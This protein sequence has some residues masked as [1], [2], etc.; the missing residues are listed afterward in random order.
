[1]SVR[2]PETSSFT[3]RSAGHPVDARR[4]VGLQLYLLPREGY[5]AVLPRPSRPRQRKRRH[6]LAVIYDEQGGS[7]EVV[8]PR[9]E[10]VLVRMRRSR[11]SY[12]PAPS[13]SPL[14]RFSGSSPS[15]ICD[16]ASCAG[17]RR[18]PVI[19]GVPD[20]VFGLT[21]TPPGLPLPGHYHAMFQRVYHLDSSTLDTYFSLS[22]ANG[23]FPA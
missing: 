23:S 14:R 12:A 8:R 4:A 10:V 18:T 21:N 17:N 13:Q 1:M 15:T 2:I 22:G 20:A 19:L 7:C 11:L 9:R 3:G 16:R 5:R 6:W